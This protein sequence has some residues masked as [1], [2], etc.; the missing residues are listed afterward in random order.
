MTPEP[1]RSRTL[2]ALQIMLVLSASVLFLFSLLAVFR[3]PSYLGWNLAIV[4]TEWGYHI[5]PAGLLFLLG[6][7][8]GPLLRTAAILG[9]LSTLLLLSPLVRAARFDGVDLITLLTGGDVIETLPRRLHYSVGATD[10]LPIDY[11]AA[12]SPGRTPP[13]VVVIHGGGW[14]GGS[15]GEF[16]GLNHVLAQ[17]GYAVASI[18]YRFAPIHRFPAQLNDVRSAIAFLQQRSAELG[19]DPNAIALIGRSAGGHLA[20]I[21]AYER[22][23]PAIKGVVSFYGPTDLIWGYEHPAARRVYDTR[24]ILEDFIGGTPS[25]HGAAYRDA[26]PLFHIRNAP[27][28][29]LIHGARDELVSVNHSRRL[30]DALERA[31]KPVTYIELPWATH[32]CDYFP[33]GPCGQASTYAVV[34]FLEG[35]FTNGGTN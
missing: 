32:S 35:V 18:E 3:A 26:S 11:Y 7:K 22:P 15:P 20:L 10:S 4:A 29:L 16:P 25:D 34:R 5:A 28:T 19:F 13:L 30:E 31:G 23:E 6:W 2:T 8:R 21:A 17:R 9:G 27:P 1:Q 14:R 12:A 24:S 33:S